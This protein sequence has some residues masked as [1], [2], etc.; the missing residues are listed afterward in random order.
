MNFV[1]EPVWNL[2]L[3]LATAVVLL[4]VVFW[5]Y[6]KRVTHLPVVWQRLLIALRFVAAI[7]LIMMMFR[8]SLLLT[9][10]D[11]E[12]SQLTILVDRSQSMTTPDGLGGISRRQT[13]INA[14]ESAQEEVEELKEQVDIQFLDFDSTVA[15]T[16]FPE[17]QAD[18]SFTA[19]GKAIDAIR[20]EA[21]GDRLLGMILM[22]DGAQRAGG[23]DDVDPLASA[24]RFAEQLGIP[25]H[26]VPIGTADVS[27]S[28]IDLAIEEIQLDQS[29]TF[30]KKTVPVHLQ[31]K[32]VG[33]A[34][35]KVKVRLLIEDR[36]GKREGESGP[37]VEIP[38]SAEAQS[39]RDDITTNENSTTIPLDLFFVAE[40]AGEYKIA[41]EVVPDQGEVKLNNNRLETLI[42]VRK[43]GL[44]VAYFDIPRTEQKFIRRLNETAKIQIDTQV[45][46][47]GKFSQQSKVD[48]AMFQQDQYDVY[49]IGD[50]PASVFQQSGDNLLG[51]LA[52]RVS[53]GAGLLMIGGLHNFGAGGYANTPLATLLPVKMEP[54]DA[55]PLDVEKPENHIN[56]KIRMLPTQIGNDRYLM[57][58]SPS[59]NRQVWEQLPE[60]GGATKLKPK[61]GA[62]TVFAESEAGDAL[63]LA[64]ETG[65][66]RILALAVDET[67]KWHLH[68]FEA[69]HQRF[70]QQMILWL[71]HKEFET[72]KPLWTKVEPRNF[73]PMAKVQ[74]EFGAQ[75]ENGVPIEGAQYQ[76]EVIKPGGETV[77]VPAQRFADHGL[78]EFT[79]TE[80]PG[81]YWV[82]V[83]GT[84]A[85]NSLGL[86]ASTR[87]VVDAR[88][89]EMD[90]P[91]ADPGMMGQIAEMTGGNVIPPEEFADFLKRIAEQGIPEEIKRYR[92]IN[93]WDGWWPLLILIGLMSIEW[94]IRKMKGLV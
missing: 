36:N 67:W 92:R 39:F 63:L 53:E 88:D 15:A 13:V 43:G 16:K 52:L 28:G 57:T 45:I 18:G 24:R 62:V 32:L 4:G 64:S 66:G 54:G 68:G 61:S 94:T 48:P 73:S 49:I 23:E 56:S 21:I 19:I 34:G 76:V 11:Q 42:T 65:R 7:V 8:P 1:V 91:A 50:V 5:T 81:D 26:A 75:S 6:P 27:S 3:V 77:K 85:G 35:K 37:L 20:E 40:Q 14:L 58:L 90:N 25:I 74:I 78:A 38:L 51:E 12:V 80:Q 55:I 9:E 86:P 10:T 30:E 71:A 59:Q 2:P 72:D 47:P 29:V 69:E 84:D 31:V 22:S 17:D 41:A 89:L 87:F 93:L 79:Q 60:L 44:K 82:R 33:A 83:S 46:L 70:W